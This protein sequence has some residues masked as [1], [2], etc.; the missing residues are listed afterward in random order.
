MKDRT[1]AGFIKPRG[2][3]KTVIWETSE[4]RRSA[5]AEATSFMMLKEQ[6]EMLDH[7]RKEEVLRP[8]F[9][10]DTVGVVHWRGKPGVQRYRERISR[11]RRKLSEA[12]YLI[13]K[14]KSYFLSSRQ[15]VD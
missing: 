11:L 5:P 3:R 10:L 6:L 8:R 14:F 13:K 7:H 4:E 12:P 15:R 9:R 1:G 2:E